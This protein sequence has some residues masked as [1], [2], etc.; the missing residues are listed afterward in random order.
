[1]MCWKQDGREV[2]CEREKRA[3]EQ[4]ERPD[5]A[6]DGVGFVS[7]EAKKPAAGTGEG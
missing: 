6:G 4:D 3:E 5:Q 1:M 7:S 2:G